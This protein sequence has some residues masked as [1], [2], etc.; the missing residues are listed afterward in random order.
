[1][2]FVSFE[3]QLSDVRLPNLVVSYITSIKTS[4]QRKKMGF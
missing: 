1:M 2:T 3:D 4:K